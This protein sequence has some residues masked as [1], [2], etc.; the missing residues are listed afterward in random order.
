MGRLNRGETTR[1]RTEA[2]VIDKAGVVVFTTPLQVTS[3]VI[4]RRGYNKMC[5]IPGKV[6]A[7]HFGG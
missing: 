1:A 6:S 4:R 7:M 5:L 3:T 2:Q